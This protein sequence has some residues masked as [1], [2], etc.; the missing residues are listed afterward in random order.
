MD[1]KAYCDA[2][3]ETCV[4][5]SFL[6]S[7]TSLPMVVFL[8]DPMSHVLSQFL[9]CKYDAWG[10]KMTNHTGFPGYYDLDHALGGFDDWVQ[11]FDHLK[12]NRTRFGEHAAYKCY[13]PYN[14][15][16]R[17]FATDRG[18]PHFVNSLADQWP[19]IDIA[20]KRLNRVQVVGIVEHYP[21]SLCL[22]EYLAG[23]Q[24]FLTEGCQVCEGEQLQ[25]VKSLIHEAHNVPPHSIDLISNVT[26]LMIQNMTTIDQQ[27]YESARG[28]FQRHVDQVREETGIDLLCRGN[29]ESLS[30]T[31]VPSFLPSIGPKEV[32]DVSSSSLWRMTTSQMLLVSL[33]GSILLV[34]IVV[35]GKLRGRGWLG[36]VRHVP[37]A[38]RAQPTEDEQVRLV[39]V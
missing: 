23:G 18:Y 3:H 33:T 29:P 24:Q 26:R 7:K 13:D 9:E 2:S 4:G 37:L 39:V 5:Q 16:S 10:K 30:P 22:F 38:N 12:T 14:M 19:N 34:L 1:S 32:V 15:Q 28:I 25:V 36:G 21:A 20:R 35:L 6:V 27:L 17:Y 11:Y 8:R 31:G